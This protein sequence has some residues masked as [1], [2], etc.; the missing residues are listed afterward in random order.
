MQRMM[1]LVAPTNDQCD[2]DED[3]TVSRDLFV[4]ATD[5]SEA[6]RL[7]RAYYELDDECDPDL[8]VLD[9]VRVFEVPIMDPQRAASSAAIGWD[10]I[11]SYGA[12][13]K[14]RSEI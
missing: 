9:K 2:G 10:D 6:V 4:W 12:T 8:G 3:G 11:R 1:Y 14:E 13:I 5:A 7:W